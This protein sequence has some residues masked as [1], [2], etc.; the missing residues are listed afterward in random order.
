MLVFTATEFWA[1]IVSTLAT[2]WL[3]TELSVIAPFVTL[4]ATLPPF[5][6]IEP[7]PN[8]PASVAGSIVRSRSPPARRIFAAA[9][10]RFTPVL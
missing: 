10:E 6:L 4:S 9:T 3:S 5:V 7:V 8:K 2:I 1:V